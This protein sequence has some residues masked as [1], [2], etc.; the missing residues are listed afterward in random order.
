[1]G[2]SAAMAEIVHDGIHFGSAALGETLRDRRKTELAS[3]SQSDHELLAHI[4][5]TSIAVHLALRNFLDRAKVSRIVYF[6][7]YAYN[8]APLVLATRRGIPLSLLSYGYNRD[9]DR[10]LFSI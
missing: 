4:V 5:W 9:I 10:R 6:G 3:L 1:M 8:I 7:D 2:D